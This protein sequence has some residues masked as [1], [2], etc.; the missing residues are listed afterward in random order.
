MVPVDRKLPMVTLTQF[1]VCHTKPHWKGTTLICLVDFFASVW[2]TSSLF[3]SLTSNVLHCPEFLKVIFGFPLVLVESTEH[4]LCVL[5][6]NQQIPIVLPD[7]C[8]GSGF[9]RICLGF[10]DFS[11]QTSGYGCD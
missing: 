5:P 2:E 1:H 11:I 8:S 7:F 9:E 3:H 4:V 6:P 10:A